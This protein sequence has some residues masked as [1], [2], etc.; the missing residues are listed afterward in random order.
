MSLSLR[1]SA[2]ILAVLLLASLAG[3]AVL[4]N[5]TLAHYRSVQD[6]RLSPLEEDRVPASQLAPLPAGAL[7]WVFFGDSRAAQWPAPALDGVVMRNLGISGADDGP[8][9]GPAGTAAAAACGPQRVLLQVGVNDL[10][11]VPLFPGRSRQIVEDTRRRLDAMV[12][13]LRASGA[14]VVLTTIFPTAA[15]PPLR[16][17]VWSDEA[18]AAIDEVN[19]HILSQA[20]PGVIVFD[21][22][23]VLRGPDGRVQPAYARDFLHLSEAG[24]AALNQALVQRPARTGRDAVSVARLLCL[25]QEHALPD[26]DLLPVL[27][28]LLRAVCADDAPPHAAEPAGGGGQLHLLRRLGPALPVAHHRGHR[29]DLRAGAGRGRAAHRALRT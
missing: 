9:A 19:R 26:D 25:E 23:A 20:G 6:L 18:D 12:A 14:E 16:R 7:P 11:T 29:R 1:R 4:L 2:W 27:H 13:A 22:A 8:G 21:A 17:L 15:V 10:K 24:Y 3:N 28:R 5:Q